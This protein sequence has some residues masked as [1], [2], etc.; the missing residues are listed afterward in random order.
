MGIGSKLKK[1]I[2]KIVPK[3]L[4]D[5][6]QVAAFIPGPHQAAAAGLAALGGYRDDG[7][8]GALKKGLGSYMGGQFTS[9]LA[10]GSQ[11][12]PGWMQKGFGS[13]AAKGS[14]FA[15]LDWLG[16][17]A[18]GMGE[19]VGSQ[20]LSPEKGTGVE[21]FEKVS[22]AG[23]DPVDVTTLDGDIYT[24][25]MEDALKMSEAGAI[26]K[27]SI[28][29]SEAAIGKQVEDT[30]VSKGLGASIGDILRQGFNKETTANLV[31]AALSKEGLPITIGMA[32]AFVQH[33]ENK[34]NKQMEYDIGSPLGFY[35]ASKRGKNLAA[36]N[37]GIIN[38]ANG[39]SP[40]VEMDYRGGGFIPVGAYERADDVPARLSKNEFVMTADAVRAAGGGSINKG[41]QVMYDL[42]NR[43]E[44]VA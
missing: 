22:G 19:G 34:K 2:K 3:E 17:Q 8:S 4:G 36:A 32:M 9:G 27:G 26:Q 35:D 21:S 38:L 30:I 13:E 43:L 7:F 28:T 20:F 42:M 41:S 25:K 24:T 5:V 23:S 29:A 11:F 10:Q 16:G 33:D 39:G 12:G 14:G 15:P 6:A 40:V 31:Q 44:G 1:A 37:G 18:H